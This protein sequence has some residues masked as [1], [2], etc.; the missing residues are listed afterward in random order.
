MPYVTCE[1]CGG[2]YELADGESPD[3]FEKCQ[4]GGK[5]KYTDKIVEEIPEPPQKNKISHSKS[6][7]KPKEKNIFK[8]ILGYI[9]N[10]ITKWNQKVNII[11]IYIG[12]AVSL[13]VPV[14]C[15]FLFGSDLLKGKIQIMSVL[16]NTF[17]PMILFGGFIT[18]LLCSKR[19]SEGI[20]NGVS[21]SL[22][23]VFNLAIIIGV[24]LLIVMAIVGAVVAPLMEAFSSVAG[25][26]SQN[27]TSSSTA[28]LDFGS[29]LGNIFLLIVLIFL[30]G[31][32]G[33]WL[34]VWVKKT[35]NAI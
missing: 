31:G 23:F 14:F 27:T 9:T 21:L 35:V 11:G 25:P 4:C 17:P 2:Y 29:Y 13:I 16:Y 18:S 1:K 33:G 12:L 28:A 3:D 24:I 20:F 15:F 30:C 22:I 10:F 7:R 8:D 19:Y 26:I 6:N 5:L 32:L 34:G